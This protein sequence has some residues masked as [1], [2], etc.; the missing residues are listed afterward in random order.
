MTNHYECHI[1]FQIS[2]RNK[3]EVLSG[4]YWKFSA[5]DGDPV[6]GAKTFCY[7]TAHDT[8][9]EALKTHMK[10]MVEIAAGRGTPA[11]RCKIEQILYDSRWYQKAEG[12]E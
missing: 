6:L 7:L 8:D 5:I 9:F 12:K 10:Y 1:T 2:D 11:V 4:Q 3:I